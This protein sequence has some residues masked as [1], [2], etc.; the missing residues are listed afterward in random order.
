MLTKLLLL[1]NEMPNK[2]VHSPNIVQNSQNTQNH[3]PHHDHHHQHHHRYHDHPHHD[4]H[5]HHHD[6]HHH[7]HDHDHNHRV[8][9]RVYSRLYSQE[10]YQL[11]VRT[12]QLNQIIQVVI[13]NI[14]EYFV[15][16]NYT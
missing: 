7:D 11:P 5:H 2:I 13:Y 9:S 15:F 12:T 14:L 1:S 10:R 3:H 8:R 4:D 6:H 16:R